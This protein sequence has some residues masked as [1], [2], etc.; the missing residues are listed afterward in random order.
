M[1]NKRESENAISFSHEIAKTGGHTF[2]NKEN[3]A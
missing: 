1:L 2:A 3:A